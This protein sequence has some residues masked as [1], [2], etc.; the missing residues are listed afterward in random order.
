MKKS[1]FVLLSA[2]VLSGCVINVKP[3]SSKSSQESSIISTSEVPTSE[4]IST[5]ESSASKTSETSASSSYITSSSQST[6][7]S[8][9]S[10]SSQSQSTSS[11]TSSS[12]ITSSTAPEITKQKIGTILS[13]KKIG[14]PVSFT[15]TLLRRMTIGTNN[16]LFFADE[17]GSIGYRFTTVTD[18]I[19]NSYRFREYDVTG[20]L[21]EYNGNLELEYDSSITD[22]YKTAIIRL[23]DGQTLSYNENETTLPKNLA[24]IGEIEDIS[25]KLTLD[26]KSHG[27][28]RQL[29]RFTAQY[30]QF[31]EDK[32]KEKTMFL[33]EN[34]K[35]VVVIMD[36][37]GTGG[38]PLYELRS[39]DNLG[40]RYEITGIISVRFS[41]PAILGLSCKYVP[42]ADESTVDISKAVELTD[43]IKTKIFTGNLT[44]DH[45][46][47][48]E[49]ALYFNLYHAAGYVAEDDESYGLTLVEGGS[50]SDSGTSTVKNGFFFVNED[51]Y[52]GMLGQKLDLYFEI[53]SYANQNHIWKIFVI[54]GLTEVIE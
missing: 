19:V 46:K 48:L 4:F 20:K 25:G 17:T 12:I 44:T 6:I 40:K 2:V 38:H 15:A 32:S 23:G 45:F 36:G 10:S 9:T 1:L 35:S 29:V 34:D 21:V 18:Y 51:H 49:N 50:I 16:V 3:A 24:N 53:E 28:D 43:E 8:Y 42:S 54:E 26:K 27:Y 47:P 41:I 33:D 11:L 52:Y 7:T 5:S 14:Q 13:E 31:E 39:E 37:D 22:S 30:V